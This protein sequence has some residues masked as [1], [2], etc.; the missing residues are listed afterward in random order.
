MCIIRGFSYC[1]VSRFRHVILGDDR[2]RAPK[3]HMESASRKQRRHPVSE[4]PMETKKFGNEEGS[5]LEESS[6]GGI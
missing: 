1:V 2:P 3:K 4:D 5:S 6:A